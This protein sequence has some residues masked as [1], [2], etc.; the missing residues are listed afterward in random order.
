MPFARWH[1]FVILVDWVCT[2]NCVHAFCAVVHTM[3]MIMFRI[4]IW[5]LCSC[6]LSDDSFDF[7]VILYY[8]IMQ[9]IGRTLYIVTYMHIN[10][11]NFIM[12]HSATVFM[13]VVMLQFEFVW[14]T[15]Q[16]VMLFVVPL[17][18]FLLWRYLSAYNKVIRTLR[19]WR[20]TAI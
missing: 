19:F 14:G 8:S 13:P 16:R 11:F 1:I 4:Y 15:F 3:Y 9:R 20:F 12:S 6:L 5:Q 17:F 18:S 7:L 2:S 10:V